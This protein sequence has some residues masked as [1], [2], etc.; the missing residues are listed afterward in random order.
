MAMKVEGIKSY[1]SNPWNYVD[2]LF[3]G[4]IFVYGYI[5]ANYNGSE[6]FATFY[7]CF[8]LM[9]VKILFYM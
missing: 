2:L 7:F 9:M 6:E 3:Y 8:I 4:S 5:E 1:F